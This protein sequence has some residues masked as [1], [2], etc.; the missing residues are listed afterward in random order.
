MPRP[1]AIA[2]AIAQRRALAIREWAAMASVNGECAA[3][4]RMSADSQDRWISLL[5][6]WTGLPESVLASADA[7]CCL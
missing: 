4:A 1:L 5:S 2:L 6:W 3:L 7:D